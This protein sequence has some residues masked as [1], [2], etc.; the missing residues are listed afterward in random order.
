MNETAW[1]NNKKRKKNTV[2][3]QWEKKKDSNEEEDASSSP[4]RHLVSIYR[5]SEDTIRR[6]IYSYLVT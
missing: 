3:H 1:M 6:K 2:F 4:V 5:Y